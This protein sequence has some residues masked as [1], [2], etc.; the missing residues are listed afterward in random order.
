MIEQI[1]LFCHFHI[2]RCVLN[3]NGCLTNFVRITRIVK[4][5]NL[6]PL[7]SGCFTSRHCLFRVVKQ[8]KNRLDPVL[9]DDK[10]A[11]VPET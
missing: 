10:V 9:S 11:A 8:K 5:V 3:D 2:F 6:A 1:N 4:D 7:L